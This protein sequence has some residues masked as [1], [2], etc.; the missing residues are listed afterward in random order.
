MNRLAS[1][2]HTCVAVAIAAVFIGGWHMANA[3]YTTLAIAAEQSTLSV[4]ASDTV[5]SGAP[6]HPELSVT[7]GDA[8]LVHGTDYA[9]I[10]RNNTNAG[11]ATVRVRGIGKFN[12]TAETTFAIAKASVYSARISGIAESYTWKGAPIAPKPLIT[13]GKKTLHEGLDYDLVYSGNTE[14][15]F[16]TLTVSGKRNLIGRRSLS[17]QII[18]T[19]ANQG[20]ASNGDASTTSAKDIPVNSQ[21]PSGDASVRGDSSASRPIANSASS[22]PASSKSSATSTLKV[23]GSPEKRAAPESV[24]KEDKPKSNV[25]KTLA[26]SRVSAASQ[27]YCGEKLC[28]KVTVLYNDRKLKQ[29][30]DYTVRY[31]N[32]VNAGIAHF[33]VYGKG[34]YCGSKLGAFKISAAPITNGKISPIPKQ[35]YTGSQIAPSVE[36]VVGGTALNARVDYSVSYKNNVERGTATVIIKGVGNYRGTNK[37]R[38]KIEYRGESIARQACEMSYSKPSYH[39]EGYDGTTRFLKDW[40][41]TCPKDWA[42][43][44]CDRIAAIS[45]RKTGA[46]NEMPKSLVDQRP[47][48]HWPN[49]EPSNNRWKRIGVYHDGD[50][51]RGKLQPGDLVVRKS[52][53]CIYV[54]K[55]IPQEVYREYLKGKTSAKYGKQGA[56]RGQ[57]SSDACWVSG[58]RNG[59]LKT[60]HNAASCIG[61]RKYARPAR[62]GQTSIIYRYAGPSL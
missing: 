18:K 56:D 28:P 16:A 50:E 22:R 11:V 34:R 2:P 19:V 8:H 13:I 37:A 1:C 40:K 36:I 31:S 41:T 32:N 46:D 15:G 9:V 35:T 49:G 62:K 38:F 25:K 29:G 3:P 39:G 57:P 12:G 42:A 20:N 44:S 5:Y 33:R 10:W 55:T 6:C 30:A 4:A 47:Y 59:G 43:R 17:Y 58:H 24:K 60:Y 23:G 27:T 51:N 14:P 52:H 48:L 54:G 7:C 61:T 45:V 53:I 26:N 21:K